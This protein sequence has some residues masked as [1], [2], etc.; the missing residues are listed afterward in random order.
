M[1]EF[2]NEQCC[3]CG[4]NSIGVTYHKDRYACDFRE[5]LDD[6]TGR[7][8]LH[9]LCRRCGY[10]WTGLTNDEKGGKE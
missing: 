10:T 7:E 5:Q 6:G 8:H 2:L 3:K 4:H 9:Y 1:S